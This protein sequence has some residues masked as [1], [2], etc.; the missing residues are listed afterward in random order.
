MLNKEL[1]CLRVDGLVLGPREG[2]AGDDGLLT[3]G[4]GTQGRLSLT[5]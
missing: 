4:D 2:D 1:D 5:A 3:A